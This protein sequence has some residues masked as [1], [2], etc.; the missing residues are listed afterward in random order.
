MKKI[1][2]KGRDGG[3][4]S[5][6]LPVLLMENRVFKSSVRE[7]NGFTHHSVWVI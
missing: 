2:I 3:L 6:M 5:Q 7:K 4:L 1:Y